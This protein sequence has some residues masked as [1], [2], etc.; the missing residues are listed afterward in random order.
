MEGRR[1]LHVP[2]AL[3]PQAQVAVQPRR[4]SATRRLGPGPHTM[5]TECGHHL[6]T[7]SG[8]PLPTGDP[9][10]HSPFLVGHAVDLATAQP[11]PL[12]RRP[13]SPSRRL[14]GPARPAPASSARFRPGRCPRRAGHGHA[15]RPRRPRPSQPGGCL[16]PPP[17]A[18]TSFRSDRARTREHTDTG[19]RTLNT[20]RRTPGRSDA[21]TG[22][23][24]PDTG[25][26]DRHAWTLD[27]RSHRTL[28]AEH[29]PRTRTRGQGHGRRPHL[30]ATTPS[31]RALGH[32]TVSCGQRLR[33]LATMTLGGGATCQRETAS[34]SAR[35]LLGRSAGLAAPQRTAVLTG[36]DHLGPGRWQPTLHGDVRA[37]GGLDGQAAGCR[38]TLWP[39][40]SSWWMR[41]RVL[42]SRSMRLA[43]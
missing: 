10:A 2:A 21:R 4:L 12:P 43:W 28:D 39:S 37:G 15:G 38:V 1:S 30:L 24:T 31:G 33:R 35:Q 27:G 13:P 41:L 11:P 17:P 14:P 5:T 3:R 40:A 22:H 42:R 19:R 25:R 26:V 16:P 36:N 23:W 7:H 32:P 18:A 20:G 6:A 34:C 8:A 9:R 29:W